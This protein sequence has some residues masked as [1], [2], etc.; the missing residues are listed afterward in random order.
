MVP[1]EVW[2]AANR[3][4]GKSVVQ[5]EEPLV[6]DEQAFKKNTKADKAQANES[7]ALKTLRKKR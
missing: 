3:G 2:D 7:D 1:A 5:R 6:L 4:D